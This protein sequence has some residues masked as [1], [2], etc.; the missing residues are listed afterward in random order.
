LLA[1]GD[2]RWSEAFPA[3][4]ALIARKPPRDVSAE[5]ALEKYDGFVIDSVPAGDFAP[6]TLAAMAKAVRTRGAGL[7][8]MNGR[9]LGSPRDAT[10]IMSYNYTPIEELLPLVSR[11]RPKEADPPP[12]HVVILIDASGSMEGPPLEM[13]QRIA[14][15]LVEKMLRAKD[16]L[17]VCAFTDVARQ[18]VTNQPMTEEGKSRASASIRSI[19]AGGGTDPSECLRSLGARKL[20]NCGLVFL[21]DGYFEKLAVQRPDC[22]TTAFG[23]GRS[24][25]APD[26]PLRDL[27]DPIP[28]GPNFDPARIKIPYFDKRPEDQYYEPGAYT[29]LGMS[30]VMDRGDA[31]ETPAIPLNGSASSYAKDDAEV[32]AVRPKLTDP[33]LAYRESSAGSAGEFTTTL[34]PEWVAHE[35]GRRAIREWIARVLPMSDQRRYVFQ[36]VQSGGELQLEISLTPRSGRLPRVEHLDAT[37]EMEGVASS[38]A[39]RPDEA[40]PDLFRGRF[41]PPASRKPVSAT[42]ILRESGPDALP[43]PQRVPILAPSPEETEM[44]VSRES[45]TY[46]LNEALLRRV[47]EA[48]GG[49]YDAL[50]Q[51]GGFAAPAGESRSE[52]I[53]PALAAAGCLCYLLAVLLRRLDI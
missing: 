29:P 45:Y 14:T 42:L 47:A 26:D 15:Y 21:S 27:A 46:G 12:R 19:E 3:N 52:P 20:P 13:E 18:L 49:A 28:V 11:P 10:N 35:D 24:W 40:V 6:G 9:H 53:W 30:A 36:L 1:V 7:F 17:D 5:E 41:R 39:V 37:L 16:S 4:S 23:I 50:E 43:R 44:P 38:I 31:T 8:L 51:V 48:G 22:R 33:V 32:M 34:P 25:F 2:D